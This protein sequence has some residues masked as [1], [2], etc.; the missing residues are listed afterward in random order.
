MNQKTTTTTFQSKPRPLPI[1]AY[2]LLGKGLKKMG[3]GVKLEENSL[4]RAARNKNKLS[5]FGEGDFITPLRKLLQSIREEAR[6]HAFGEFI[7]KIRLV[8]ILENRL[9]ATYYFKK[10]PEILEQEVDPLWVITGLQRTGTTKLHRLLSADPTTRSLFSWE[11]LNPA[12]IIGKEQQKPDPRIRLAQNSEKGL[13]YI[14]PDFFA[15]HPVEHNAPEE[16][17]LLLDTSFISTVP[18]AT[19]HVPSFAKWVENQDQTPA[20]EMMQKMLKLLQWQHRGKRWILKTP[21]HLEFLDTLIQ[22]FPGT[23]IIHT[24]RNPVV[25]L[26]SFCSMVY[27][28]RRIF[29][30]QVSPEEVGQHWHQKICRMLQKAQEYRQNHPETPVI[31]L[32]YDHLIKNPL[33]EIQRIYTFAGIA[34]EESLEEKLQETLDQNPPNKYGIHHYQLQDFGLEEAKVKKDFEA[35]LENFA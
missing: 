10:H 5:D 23:K 28:G 21:H 1:Q 18:E 24:H 27:H 6:L 20:Y 26:A 3:L 9:R 15:I 35:Y 31:D 13:R 34:W 33:S 29:S 32:Y 14:A 30:D 2:N 16:E 19:M 17:V 11:A 12:P 4:L 8:G 7:T 22:V 25:T